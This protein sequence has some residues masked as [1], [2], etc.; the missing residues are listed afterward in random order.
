MPH[1]KQRL[2]FA[3]CKDNGLSPAEKLMNTGAKPYQIR[4]DASKMEGNR[5]II[6]GLVLLGRSGAS[7]IRPDP[8]LKKA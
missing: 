3:S 8:L 4:P 7:G 2:S 6:R 1:T 5:A